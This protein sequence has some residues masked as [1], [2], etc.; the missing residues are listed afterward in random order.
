MAVQL[1]ARVHRPSNFL[2]VRVRDVQRLISRQGIDQVFRDIMDTV[3]R[4]L[5]RVEGIN[6]AKH[7]FLILNFF[8]SRGRGNMPRE[9]FD[10]LGYVSNSGSAFSQ[11][12]GNHFKI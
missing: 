12:L 5:E 9:A 6:G 11:N 8:K 3:R 10:V 2:P 4:D 1:D 7:S